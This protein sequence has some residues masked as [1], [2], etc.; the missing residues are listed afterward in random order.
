VCS[1]LNSSV[2]YFLFSMKLEYTKQLRN[3]CSIRI[4]VVSTLASTVGY[5]TSVLYS[6]TTSYSCNFPTKFQF[7]T[8]NGTLGT[9]WP[10]LPRR[11][12]ADQG[13]PWSY[14]LYATWQLWRALVS[15]ITSKTTTKARLGIHDQ[16]STRRCYLAWLLHAT[17]ITHRTVQPSNNQTQFH[18]SYQ[19]TKCQQSTDRKFLR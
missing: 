13:A 19:A 16:Q 1:M 18:A 17:T 6:T 14:F 15:M 7:P 2:V 11:Q 8:D 5:C 10:L 12:M 4:C 9:I 3:F